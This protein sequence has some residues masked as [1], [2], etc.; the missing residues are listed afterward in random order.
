LIGDF[1]WYNCGIIRIYKLIIVIWWIDWC[2][3]WI[4]I[5]MCCL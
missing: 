1:I 2:F 4:E 3:E 5:W